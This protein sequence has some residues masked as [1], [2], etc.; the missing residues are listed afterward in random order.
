VTGTLSPEDYPFA[1]EEPDS[2]SKARKESKQLKLKKGYLFNY[3]IFLFIINS[4]QPK[5][6]KRVKRKWY[7]YFLQFAPFPSLFVVFSSSGICY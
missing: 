4:A 3:L 5:L 1:G 6:L 2:D 7:I